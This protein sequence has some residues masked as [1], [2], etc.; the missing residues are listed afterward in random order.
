MGDKSSAMGHWLDLLDNSP[1]D[2]QP[3]LHNTSLFQNITNFWSYLSAAQQEIET[4]SALSDQFTATHPE[5]YSTDTSAQ[6][7]LTAAQK[8]VMTVM[9]EEA[10]NETSIAM[11]MGELEDAVQ[12]VENLDKAVH[13]GLENGN[14]TGH[15]AG[16]PLG[17]RAW[18]RRGRHLPVG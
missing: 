9:Q 15:R 11:A 14:L 7:R 17:T 13:L 2:L 10:Y 5:M 6:D 4:A 18:P 1:Q 12:E 3:P 8:E 16:T